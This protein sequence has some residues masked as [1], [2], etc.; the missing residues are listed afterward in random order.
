[1]SP[2]RAGNAALAVAAG[3]AGARYRDGGATRRHLTPNAWIA[4]TNPLAIAG[5]LAPARFQIADAYGG[6][7]DQGWSGS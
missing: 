6:S 3:T 5:Q 1:M 7:S 2:V 4:A